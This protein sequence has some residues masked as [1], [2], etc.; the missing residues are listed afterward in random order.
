VWSTE[1]SWSSESLAE[2]TE[3]C[4]AQLP[5]VLLCPLG[6]EARHERQRD[7]AGMVQQCQTTDKYFPGFRLGSSRL[8]LP[9]TDGQAAVGTLSFSFL[10]C[11]LMS[12]FNKTVGDLL[13]LR[14]NKKRKGDWIYLMIDYRKSRYL[15]TA[16]RITV[17]MILYQ[18]Q[19]PEDES[20]VFS[21]VGTRLN[22]IQLM[23][24]IKMPILTAA[25]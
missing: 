2:G 17:K 12:K 24:Q 13:G 22:Q 3:K 10:F 15:L 19:K 8:S 9:E 21:V 5:A 25:I 11:W 4:S 20:N 6:G 23:Q 7:L 1:G 14:S 18:Q 16:N